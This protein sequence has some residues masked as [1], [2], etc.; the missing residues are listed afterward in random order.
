M[1]LNS[2]PNRF[3]FGLCRQLGI[4]KAL[5][6]LIL[7]KRKLKVLVKN[8]YFIWHLPRFLISYLNF[9]AISSFNCN[10]IFS[11]LLI[12]QQHKMP[13]F[14]LQETCFHF[15]RVG[16]AR[17]TFLESIS[18]HIFLIEIYISFVPIHVF[19]FRFIFGNK[20][21]FIRNI[22]FSHNPNLMN[23]F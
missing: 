1:P 7:R 9:W 17:K 8:K 20:F 2:R 19:E 13:F 5:G 16:F 6:T 14:F 18:M 21:S 22:S 4:D 11:N 10:T 15:P 12:D 23:N 3:W